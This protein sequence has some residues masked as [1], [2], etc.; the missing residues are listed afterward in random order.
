MNEFSMKISGDEKIL[1]MFSELPN[2]A[3]NRILKP[4]VREGGAMLALAIRDEAPS[5]SGLMKIAIGASSLKTYA[6]DGLLFITA[7]VRRG[8]RRAVQAVGRGGLRH[9][10]KRKSAMYPELPVQDPARYLHLVTGGRTAVHALNRAALYDRRTGRF[11]GKSVASAKANP[12]V[13]RTFNT[14][15]PTVTNK[16]TGDATS[17]IM[18]EAES[19]LKS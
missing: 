8:Y 12:F 4:L 6:S 10:S 16:I 3:Q 11:F 9:F 15:G 14:A 13:S 19:L 1:R 5:Q 18:A 17:R 7:G 2:A